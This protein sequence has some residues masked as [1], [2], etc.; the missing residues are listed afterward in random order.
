[1][2]LEW[3]RDLVMV[4]LGIVVIGVLIFLSVLNFSLYK[5][6]KELLKATKDIL[7][8]A[9]SVSSF[10]EEELVKPLIHVA[11]ILQGVRMGLRAFSR[12]WRKEEGKKHE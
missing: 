3:L 1:M 6:A 12:F 11:A 2:T 7:K 5:E 9:K 4:I 8:T 10:I